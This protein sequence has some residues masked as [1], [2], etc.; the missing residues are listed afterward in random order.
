MNK[1]KTMII[2]AIII[3]VISVIGLSYAFWSIRLTQTGNN[4]ILTQCFN[5]SLTNEQ[6]KI[7]LENGYPIT[8]EE[9]K[10][11]TPYSFTI[12]NTCDLFASY[13]VQLEITDTSTLPTQY[14]RTMINDEKI[15]NLNEYEESTEHVNTNTKETRI[16]AKGSL[17]KGES[18]D[19]TFRL[20]IDSDVTQ[21]TSDAIGKK[22]SAKIA[23]IALP[24]T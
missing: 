22:I 13:V 2:I 1:K 15:L 11:L 3:L 19:F 4:K 10:K 17:S 18:K 24:S 7:Q 5:L 9:G 8:D 6:N 12:T 14:I 21:E 23:V 16:L 20:W